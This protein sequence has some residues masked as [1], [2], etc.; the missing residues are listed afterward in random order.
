MVATCLVENPGTKETD[1]FLKTVLDELCSK[2]DQRTSTIK[3]TTTDPMGLIIATGEGGKPCPINMETFRA[4]LP[5]V[6][7][8]QE[9]PDADDKKMSDL[10]LF[11]S[12]FQNIE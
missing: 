12:N 6:Y 7:A 2:R 11:R 1:N 8:G 5:T 10:M 9:I 4:S 3:Q